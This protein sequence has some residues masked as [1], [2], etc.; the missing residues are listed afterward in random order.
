MYFQ[1][2]SN[3]AYPQHSGER[4]RTSGPV[5]L[6]GFE[7]SCIALCFYAIIAIKHEDLREDWTCP[8]ELPL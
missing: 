7:L 2:C 5:D 6:K 1:V 8:N 3:S 4:Y